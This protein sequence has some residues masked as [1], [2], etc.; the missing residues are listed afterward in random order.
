MNSFSGVLFVIGYV[1]SFRPPQTRRTF[2]TLIPAFS[3]GGGGNRTSSAVPPLAYGRRIFADLIAGV[4][5]KFESDVRNVGVSASAASKRATRGAGEVASVLD[6]AISKPIANVPSAIKTLSNPDSWDLLQSGLNPLDSAPKMIGAF[7]ATSTK[8]RAKMK[9]KSPEFKKKPNPVAPDSLLRTAR[10]LPST[11]KYN[12]DLRV[13]AREKEAAALL[14]RQLGDGSDSVSVSRSSSGSNDYGE[15]TVEDAGEEWIESG[16]RSLPPLNSTTGFAMEKPKGSVR[17]QDSQSPTTTNTA[18][19]LEQAWLSGSTAINP[20]AYKEED[21]EIEIDAKMTENKINSVVEAT[22]GSPSIQSAVTALETEPLTTTQ[23]IEARATRNPTM[24][25]NASSTARGEQ[26][27]VETTLQTKTVLSLEPE[28]L[29]KMGATAIDLVFFLAETAFKAVGP[30]IQ[31][32]GATAVS[33]IQET[34]F[35]DDDGLKRSKTAK[36]KRPPDARSTNTA[37]A[38]VLAEPRGAEEVGTSKLL[39]TLGKQKSTVL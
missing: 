15:S 34:L 37:L 25:A 35:P 4:G 16:E 24:I 1:L 8:Q 26:L 19:A 27:V 13:N 2:T 23:I 3:G 5:A 14:S 39:G 11:L 38:P 22:K 32:G 28:E 6:K 10:T 30:I 21:E 33:R 18:A 20:S 31:D 36:E 9:R 29:T 7:D 12:W 17:T